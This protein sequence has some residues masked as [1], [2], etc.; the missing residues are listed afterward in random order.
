MFQ[1]IREEPVLMTQVDS[2]CRITCLSLWTEKCPD[3][4]SQ[5]DIKPDSLELRNSTSK[6][7][8]ELPKQG[9]TAPPLK[10]LLKRTKK[11]LAIVKTSSGPFI[12][13]PIKVRNDKRLRLT[14]VDKPAV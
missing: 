14:F 11:K 9:K 7:S 1:D 8:V 6:L 5:P 3:P 13:E 10:S 2:T 4:S 12:A